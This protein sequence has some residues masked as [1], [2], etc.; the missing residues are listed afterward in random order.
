MGSL[1]EV[2]QEQ[3]VTDLVLGHLQPLPALPF[4]QPVEVHMG[5]PP[6]TVAQSRGQG[7]EQEYQNNKKI[8]AILPEEL[9]CDR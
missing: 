8:L 5:P 3:G 9:K 1:L 7:A 4:S 6:H 2:T